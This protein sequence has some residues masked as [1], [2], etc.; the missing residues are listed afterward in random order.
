MCILHLLLILNIFLLLWISVVSAVPVNEQNLDNKKSASVETNDTDYDA[1]S[2][3]K[4]TE[5]SNSDTKP[6][7]VFPVDDKT[8]S[9]NDTALEILQKNSN[10]SIINVRLIIIIFIHFFF[11]KMNLHEGQF[12]ILFASFDVFIPVFIGKWSFSRLK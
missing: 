11:S 2:V 12:H 1:I 10:T 6:P 8:T 4:P 7:L 9:K 5:A 3:D